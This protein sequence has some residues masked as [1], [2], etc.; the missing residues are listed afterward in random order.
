MKCRSSAPC[1]ADAQEGSY[2]C[3]AHEA[4]MAAIKAR[5]FTDAGTVRA[6]PA[7]DTP[8]TG[9]EDDARALAV[10]VLRDGTL[11][12]TQLLERLSFT[13]RQLERARTY[14]ER[15]GWVSASTR[16][17][18]PG[19]VVPD[20]KLPVEVRAAMIVRHVRETGGTVPADDIAAAV[21]VS[22]T[23]SFARALA[24]AVKD[25]HVTTKN[26]VGG[27]VTAVPRT[28]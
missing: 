12:K 21:G 9:L 1:S 27:G 2:F 22:R 7:T 28:A 10:A 13:Q 23:G 4:E 18:A 15:Q 26:G 20:G 3:P 5:W 25:G 11:T 19:E 17:L 8:S 24:L 14:A 16:G 6:T